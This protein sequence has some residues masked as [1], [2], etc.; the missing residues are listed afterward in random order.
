MRY[1]MYAKQ[2][3]VA[4]LLVVVPVLALAANAPKTAAPVVPEQADPSTLISRSAD[5][6]LREIEMHRAELRKDPTRLHKLVDDMLLPNFD[7][8]YAGQ[9]VLGRHWRAATPQQRQRFIDA[10]YKSMLATYGDAMVEFTANRLKVLPSKVDP[11]AV[12]ATVRSEVKRSSGDKVQVNYSMRK[13]NGAWKAWDVVIDGI[14]YV[15][16][17]R[18]DLGAEIEQK[19]LEQ[20]ITRLEESTK[21]DKSPTRS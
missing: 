10:F 18:E 9:L 13:V 6:L 7:S 11:T 5:V 3:I 4:F 2:S 21:A 17:F 8:A 15:K 14:S 20:L 16:S 1:S 19:G 12:R